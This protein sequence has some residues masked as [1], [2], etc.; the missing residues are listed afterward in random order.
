[1]NNDG[2]IIAK[3]KTTCC[4]GAGYVGGCTMAVA[5]VHCPEYQFIVCDIDE[6][7]IAASI[8]VE[9]DARASMD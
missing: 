9:R 2:N 7:R 5:A 8:V 4:I 1:M 3:K 6:K